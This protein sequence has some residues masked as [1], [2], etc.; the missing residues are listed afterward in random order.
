MDREDSYAATH[1]SDHNSVF[2]KGR[3]VA[4]REFRRTEW[5][6]RR[7]K[8]G[9][10]IGKGK[11]AGKNVELEGRYLRGR[12]HDF[13]F[14][15]PIPKSH[16]YGCPHAKQSYPSACAVVCFLLLLPASLFL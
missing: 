12:G 4:G 16:E 3:S 6:K 5:E 11:S 14:S 9:K 15:S 13:P 1:A 2:I 10:K 7:E 8:E